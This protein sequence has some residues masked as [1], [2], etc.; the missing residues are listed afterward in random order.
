MRP[1]LGTTYDTALES[2][3]TGG[4]QELIK[5]AHYLSHYNHEANLYPL[6]N[7]TKTVTQN[8]VTTSAYFIFLTYKLIIQ[9]DS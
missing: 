9:T 3:T 6:L 1:S 7:G 8:P 4:G 5:Y 2:W